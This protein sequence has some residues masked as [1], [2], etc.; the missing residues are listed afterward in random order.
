MPAVARF[1]LTPVKSTSLHHPEA[2]FLGQRG[3][4]VDRRFLFV[5]AE[6]RRLSDVAKAPLLGIRARYDPASEHLSLRFPDGTWCEGDA[7]EVGQAVS[8]PL[9][10]RDV[11]ARLVLGPFAE[12]ASAYTGRE[13]RLARVEPQESAGGSHRVSIVSSASIQDLARRGGTESLDGR[14]FRMLV[15]VDGSAPHEEDGWSDQRLR[16]GEAVVR[17]GASI[18]RCV[19]TT[20]HPDSGEQDFPTLRVLAGHRKREGGLMFGV[21]GDVERAGLV[22]VGDP[23]EAVG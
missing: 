17:V 10:D 3:V 14:R 20:L 1:N 23:V 7:G 15:E 13:L 5:D 11:A 2:V 22:R 6:G 21:Y 9:F 16:L 19:V 4:E 18:P 8:I 12:A